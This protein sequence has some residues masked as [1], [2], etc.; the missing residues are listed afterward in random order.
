MAGVNLTLP[1]AAKYLLLL[2][3]L[4]MSFLALSCKAL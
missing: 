3:L 4:A 2:L 1:S